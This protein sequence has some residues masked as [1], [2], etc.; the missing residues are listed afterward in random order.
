MYYASL[1]QDLKELK[2]DE[3][4]CK[5]LEQSLSGSV[6]QLI[7]YQDKV[8]RIRD[9]VKAS[10]E[11]I[12]KEI[13]EKKV[14][15]AGLKEVEKNLRE[16]RD[17]EM[18]SIDAKKLD[19]IK[20]FA[21][22]NAQDKT[23]MFVLDNMC[24]WIMG[25]DKAS[26]AAVGA[27]VFESVDVLH[28]GI[29]S[30]DGKALTY[31]QCRDVMVMI[32]GSGDSD[33]VGQITQALIDPRMQKTYIDFYCFFKTFSKM[34]HWCMNQLKDEHA[35]KKISNLERKLG[36][37]DANKERNRRIEEALANDSDLSMMV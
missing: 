35:A 18:K 1:Q 4:R 25:D 36:D 24:K 3:V 37:K 16:A 5:Q 21:K 23:I 11:D 22:K 8:Q 28:E 27:Q 10:N 15:R 29:R 14:L 12:V 20:A 6:K 7:Q 34:I 13:E 9:S 19:Q 17:K 30:M 2:E 33:Q 31:E 32:G 26:Y